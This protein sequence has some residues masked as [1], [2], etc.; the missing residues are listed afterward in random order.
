MTRDYS[1]QSFLGPESE[2]ILRTTKIGIAGAGGGGSHVCQQLAHLGCQNITIADKQCIENSNLN[3]LVGAT[4]QDVI[5][6]MPKVRIAERMI[7]GVNPFAHVQPIQKNWQEAQNELRECAVI[8]GCVDSYEIREQLEAFARRFCIVYIDIGMDVYPVGDHFGISGQ[9]VVSTP[10]G[11]CLKCLGIVTEH[12]L[13]RE[14]EQY[15]A[16]GPNPQVVWSNGVLAS[17]AVGAFVQLVAPWH[18]SHS[19]TTYLEY[20]GNS[21]TISVSNRLKHVKLAPCTH[22]G[23]ADVGDPYFKL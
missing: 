9:V 16:A 17:T 13:K 19:P 15:G 22:Y 2:D 23:L 3:R 14:A 1:R 6:K 7:K 12:K 4:W 8:F 5:E 21:G 18:T 20:D 11:P 10:G